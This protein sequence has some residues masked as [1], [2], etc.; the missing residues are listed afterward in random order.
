MT[1][2]ETATMSVESG[3]AAR[4]PGR[5]PDAAQTPS[6]RCQGLLMTH[7]DALNVDSLN[8]DSTAAHRFGREPRIGILV[9]AYNAASTLAATLD[10]I[11]P[12]FRP[13]I[14]EVFVCDDASPDSTYLVGLGYQ[15]TQRDLPISVIRHQHN[16]G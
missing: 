9:V 13:K 7:L 5:R 2:R 12:E 14:A 8:V 15:E 4:L 6:R 3:P 1:A 16:L 11:P 10:R